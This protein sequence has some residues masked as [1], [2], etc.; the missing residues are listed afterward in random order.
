MASEKRIERS[1][2][3]LLREGY[4]RRTLDG[5]VVE[6]EPL[7]TTSDEKSNERAKSFHS[8]SLDIAKRAIKFHP[9]ESRQAS[10]VVL[11]LNES[12]FNDLK[13]MLKEFYEKVLEFV[14]EHS[15][16]NEQLY[17]VIIHLSPVGGKSP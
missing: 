6:N 14:E 2:E 16:D 1:L 3:Y 9:M 13:E 17:Q 11:A 10:A 12:S 7:T 8:H 4:L 5:R 15:D